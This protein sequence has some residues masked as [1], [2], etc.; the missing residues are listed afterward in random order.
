[1]VV[2][3][4]LYACNTTKYVPDDKKLLSRNIVHVDNESI[5]EDEIANIIR[6]K[7]NKRFLRVFRLHLGFYNLSKPGSE[8]WFSR[9][10][11][12]IGEEPVIYDPL[13]T[14][15][16]KTQ[17][18]LFLSNKG[19]FNAIVTDTLIE[20]NKELKAVYNVK[21]GIPYK[22]TSIQYKIEDTLIYKYVIADTS[23]SLLK[24]GI[25]FDTDI[26]QLERARIEELL[27]NKAYFNF[28]KDYI[29]YEAD[30]TV[31]KFDVELTVNI[32]NFQ[33]RDEAGNIS[34][35]N[36]SRY[37]ISNISV[38]IENQKQVDTSFNEPELTVTQMVE[39]NKVRIIYHDGVPIKPNTIVNNIYISDNQLY[40]QQ[41]VDE[42]YRALSSLKVFRYINILFTE[43]AS[44]ADDSLKTVDCRIQL[45]TV[46]FQS[47][48][49]DAEVT[50]SS[51]FGVAGSFS[52]QHKNL[53]KG[54]E[55]LNLKFKGATEAVKKQSEIEFKNTLELGTEVSIQFPKFL[56]PFNTEKFTRKYNPKTQVTGSFNYM[57]RIRYKYQ[58][59]NA[60]FGYTWKGS[61]YTS[62]QIN[63]LEFNYIRMLD[64]DSTF[65]S[66][67]AKTYLKYSFE[68][69][70]LVAQHRLVLLI[71]TSDRRN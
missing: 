61:S 65:A 51:G 3:L 23:A 56:L 30:S 32:K 43:H 53:F 57:S 71:I 55:L 62:Y 33:K 4:F 49:T 11:R 64:V 5:H 41:N 24:P 69:H 42:T 58:V 68:D 20:R 10:F 46:N 12:K 37:K 26:L 39:R 21:T 25:N 22:I 16:S 29:Y 60:T 15:K 6:Q 38:H 36:H 18:Q 1:M 7:P 52:Y 9:N 17:I 28:T 66:E 70:L 59:A 44:S 40:N 67:I 63:P 27:K 50:N 45:A 14:E 8:K 35:S 19:Y 34:E 47:Y 2:F 13:L 54:A 31:G 48:Q